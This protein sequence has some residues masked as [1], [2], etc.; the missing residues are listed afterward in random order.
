MIIFG[1]MLGLEAI[2]IFQHF[3]WEAAHDGPGFLKISSIDIAGFHVAEDRL[4]IFTAT[5]AA[6]SVLLLWLGIRFIMPGRYVPHSCRDDRI[7]GA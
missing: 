5:A 6:V 3:Q 4:G 1:G 2:S 7:G